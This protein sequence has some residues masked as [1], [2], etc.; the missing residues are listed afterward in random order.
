MK[1]LLVIS[2]FQPEPSHIRGL[3]FAKEMARQG[4]SVQVLTGFP[5]YPGGKLYPGYKM[6]WRLKEVMDGIEVVRV[7]HYL[8]HDSSGFRRFLNYFSFAIAATCIG[9]FSVKRPDIIHVCEGAPTLMLPA[10]VMKLFC[11]V[12]ILLDVQDLWP[13]SVV[14][15]GMLH[16]PAGEAI[17]HH[18]CNFTY[19]MSNQIVVLSSGYKTLLERRGVPADA[20]KVVYNWCDESSL[21]DLEKNEVFGTQLGLTGRF[22]VIFA[23]TMGKVQALDAVLAAAELVKD[24]LPQVQ[25]VFVGGGVELPRLKVMA[26]RQRLTNVKFIPRQP[27]SEISRILAFAD[28]L[29]IHLRRDVLGSVGIPQKTQAYLASGKPIIVAVDGEAASIV[30]TAKAGFACEPENPDSIASAIRKLTTMSSESR[31]SLGRNGRRWY[32]EHFS[33]QRGIQELALVYST[34]SKK[35]RPGTSV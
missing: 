20:V 30:E 13:E 9:I 31:E 35:V 17:L 28:A 15:S 8:S 22:N 25:F 26:E 16:F 24:E 27:V 5:N 7:A 11:R 21:V 10:I 2:L 29:L 3:S 32:V 1:I 34:V 14:S 19:R 18:W 4:H 6:R 33:F 23:G 12:P